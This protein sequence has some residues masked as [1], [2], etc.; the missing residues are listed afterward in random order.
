MKPTETASPNVNR[1]NN[2]HSTA[3]LATIDSRKQSSESL[4]YKLL[5]GTS[6]NAKEQV[7]IVTADNEVVGP[8]CRATMRLQNLWHRAT[9]ILVRHVAEH[10]GQHED[11]Y[12][13]VQRRSVRKDYCPG[14]LD[15]TPGGVVGF[16]ESYRHNAER[17]LMEEMGIDSSRRLTRLFTFPYQ[18]SRVK[19]WG[20]FYECV[21]NGALHD[22]RLQTEEVD[23]VV[24]MSLDELQRQIQENAANFMPDSCHAMKLYFQHRHDRRIKRRLF[25]GLSSSNLDA[26]GLRPKP[27]AIFFDCDDCLYFDN[28]TLA[29][30]LTA[31]I[32]EWCVTHGGL[33]PG[34]AYELYKQYGTALRGLLAEGYI[35]SNEEAID[36]FLVFVHSIPVKELL[37]PDPELRSMLLRMDPSVPRYI[38][39]ASVAHHARRCLE[40]LGIDDLFV[41]IIDCRNC[42]FESKHSHH[43]F[44]VAMKIASVDKPELCLFFDD[45]ATNIR[46]ASEIGWRS[47]LVGRIGRDCGKAITSDHAELEVD[48]IHDL[49]RVLAELFVGT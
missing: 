10:V 22:L 43:S 1:D 33:R 48:R 3:V 21:Y 41:G 29:K 27:K 2:C 30:Q 40:A 8:A 42:D 17:E 46:A 15:P 28:W 16:G 39:T 13:L 12:V 9:Y 23:E 14:L 36:Q 19:V 6:L 24:R 7:C 34:H 45:N 11:V 49:P 26:Y 25:H 38:F 4:H 20:D 47:V 44:Q 35:E 5:S 31:K 18:D 37:R 32:D